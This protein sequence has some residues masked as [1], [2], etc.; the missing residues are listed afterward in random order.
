[1]RDDLP[2]SYPED[3]IIEKL[4]AARN[5]MNESKVKEDLNFYPEDDAGRDKRE[6]S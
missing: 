5:A 6:A 1:M 3:N 2:D 4:K